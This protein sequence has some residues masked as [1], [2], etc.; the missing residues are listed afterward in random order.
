M[1]RR[2]QIK[3]QLSNLQE[4]CEDLDRKADWSL[5]KC[6]AVMGQLAR[7]EGKMY[8]IESD[9]ER[10][11]DTVRDMRQQMAAGN[12]GDGRTVQERVHSDTW[13]MGDTSKPHSPSESLSGTNAGTAA[14]A[15][16]ETKTAAN[17][18]TA[19]ISQL[20]ERVRQLE[21]AEKKR[22][23]P[24]KRAWEWTKKKFKKAQSRMGFS[25]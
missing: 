1:A 12:R 21:A 19:R 17:E 2:S 14:S 6:D 15:R 22:G 24:V 8:A 13:W 3:R 23:K 11:K 9:F 7:T 18:T 5:A 25:Q 4:K 10:L 20:A 16:S